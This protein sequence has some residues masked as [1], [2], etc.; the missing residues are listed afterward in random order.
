MF[1]GATVNSPHYGRCPCT[2]LLDSLFD[3]LLQRMADEHYPSTGRQLLTAAIVTELNYQSDSAQR[4]SNE[5]TV[6]REH[7]IAHRAI[8]HMKNSLS[9]PFDM[10]AL[11]QQLQLNPDYF[12]RTFK[13]ATGQTPQHY[14][15]KLRIDAARQQLNSGDVSVTEVARNLGFEDA[16][17]FS[18]VFKRV[19]GYS[20]GQQ[21]GQTAVTE[22][23]DGEFYPFVRRV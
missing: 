19:T 15:H 17:Y 21:R 4:P 22:N 2:A 8:L 14:H 5:R 6:S 13:A 11:A 7:D 23:V 1:R 12:R 10:A 3:A 18:R 16:A 20:P 9:T